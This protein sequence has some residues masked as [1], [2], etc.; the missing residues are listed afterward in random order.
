M[1]I[2]SLISLFMT[3]QVLSGTSEGR[4]KYMISIIKMNKRIEMAAIY[5]YDEVPI[6][7][8]EWYCKYLKKKYRFK[9]LDARKVCT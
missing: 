1:N 6:E 2:T 4:I 8:L 5:K 9:S 7:T 3:K